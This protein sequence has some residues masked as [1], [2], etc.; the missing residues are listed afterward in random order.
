MR[1]SSSR[2]QQ[3]TRLV[4]V[5]YLIHLVEIGRLDPN[6]TVGSL[7]NL[8]AIK[9]SQI[10]ESLILGL[11]VNMIWA[12]Q[13][14]L[15]K[16][17][18]LSGFE[19]VSNVLEFKNDKFRLNGL[20][21]L[22]H[23]IGLKFSDIDFVEQ[24]HFMQMEVNFSAIHYDSDPMLKCLFVESI[25]RDKYGIDAAQ[26]ARGIIFKKASSF[27]ENYSLKIFPRFINDRDL[28][29]SVYERYCLKLQHEIIFCFLIIYLFRNDIYS[30]SLVSM[31]VAGMESYSYSRSH[32]SS[33]SDYNKVGINFHDNIDNAINKIMFILDSDENR[34][35]E[36][37]VVLKRIVSNVFSNEK[38]SVS[39]I[40]KNFSIGLRLNSKSL[41]LLDHVIYSVSKNSHPLKIERFTS[42]GNLMDRLR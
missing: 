15:G 12:E 6:P 32:I 11:P 42:V 33:Y 7:P 9:K 24:K 29:R 10:V 35:H 36:Y 4:S 14:A 19:I 25:N 18:L 17:Q 2:I 20:R 21:I 37:F 22:K 16:T 13:D 26:L 3:E 39:S 40:G 31:E 27:I 23:L 30:N 28:S 8:S 5:D 41:S 1:Y 34:L 38:I